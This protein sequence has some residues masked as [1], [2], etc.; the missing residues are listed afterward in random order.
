MVRRTHERIHETDGPGNEINN[1]SPDID[2]LPL[3]REAV[4][5]GEDIVAEISDDIDIPEEDIDTEDTEEEIDSEVQHHP[6]RRYSTQKMEQMGIYDQLV[7]VIDNP[8]AL[9]VSLSDPDAIIPHS[10]IPADIKK[11]VIETYGEEY[12]ESIDWSA[13]R[14]KRL[15]RAVRSP[16]HNTNNVAAQI[17]G[18]ICS[19]KDACP[20]DIVGR[21]PLGERCPIELDYAKTIYNE[22]VTAIAERLNTDEQSIKE[23]IILNNHI[24]NLVVNEMVERR[25]DSIIARDGVSDD[26]PVFMDEESGKVF[27]RKDE[28]TAVKMKTRI[29]KRTDGI[30]RQLLATPEMAEKYRQ[31]KSVDALSRTSEILENIEKKIMLMVE[32]KISNAQLVDDSKKSE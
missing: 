18:P 13:A 28:S 23:N 6:V 30:L 25:M 2:E 14:L 5:T 16:R 22:Y 12:F 19:F 3:E 20:Y 31:K 7:T 8:A 11:A 15:A 24:N 10:K 17:C 26:V 32:G 21:A 9:V 27:C 4:S 1:I 29:A